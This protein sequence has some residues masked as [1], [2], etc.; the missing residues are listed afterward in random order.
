MSYKLI[1]YT[2]QTHTVFT[3]ETQRENK[4]YVIYGISK[5]QNY[6]AGILSRNLVFQCFAE[7]SLTVIN[8]CDDQN[9]NNNKI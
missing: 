3:N 6:Y 5:I 7:T 8:K 4:F 1:S 9:N 2:L